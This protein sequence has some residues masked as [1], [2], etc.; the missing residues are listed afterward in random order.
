MHGNIINRKIDQDKSLAKEVICCAKKEL[1]SITELR[2]SDFDHPN[3]Q[4]GGL[5]AFRGDKS[6]ALRNMLTDP[7]FANVEI[8]DKNNDEECCYLIT[9]SRVSALLGE[10]NWDILSWTSPITATLLD[11]YA[12]QE[13]EYTGPTGITRK[14]KV[15]SFGKY[16]KVSPSLSDTTYKLEEG[17]F[18]I[19]NEQEIS[20]LGSMPTEKDE[21]ISTLPTKKPSSEEYVVDEDFGLDEIIELADCDQRQTM[22]LPFHETLIIEGPPGSGKTS[23]AIMRIP[24]LIDRQWEELGIDISKDNPFHDEKTMVILVKNNEMVHYLSN[25]T[26]SLGITS[27]RVLGIKDFLRDVCRECQVLE[28]Q[29][30]DESYELSFFKTMPNIFNLFQDSFIGYVKAYWE[31]R[32]SEIK[33]RLIGNYDDVLGQ[34]IEKISSKG[35]KGKYLSF[36][37]T[38]KEKHLDGNG[39]GLSLYLAIENWCNSLSNGNFY[40]LA[41]RMKKWQDDSD[42]YQGD[43]IKFI[44]KNKLIY[45]LDYTE[46]V[47]Q[48]KG[49]VENTVKKNNRE[50]RRRLK[51]FVA[52]FFNRH[53]IIDYVKKHP[54]ISNFE[55]EFRKAGFSEIEFNNAMDEWC[56]QIESRQWSEHDLTL[57]AYLGLKTMLL[58]D[59]NTAANKTPLLGGYKENITHMVIDEA[60]DISISHAKFFQEYIKENGTLTFCGDLHQRVHSKGFFENWKDL[61]LDDTKKIVFSKNFRQ[62]KQLGYFVKELYSILFQKYPDWSE[63]D[64]LIGPPPR[65]VPLENENEMTGKICQEIRHWMQMIPGAKIAVLWFSEYEHKEKLN[66]L[67]NEIEGSLDDLLI[68]AEVF[69]SG[70]NDNFGKG[71]VTL[72]SA[73]QIKGLEFDVVICLDLNNDLDMDFD[74]LDITIKNAIYVVLSRSQYGL[75]MIL[76]PETTIYPKLNSIVEIN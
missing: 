30:T 1:K 39:L 32:K 38:N 69:N 75:S 16:G 24:C 6:Q 68:T 76:S 40:S 53:G 57:M 15:L 35:K 43:W 65:L 5:L 13:I 63:T 27:V 62:T 66:K 20:Y 26:K 11:S 37:R 46:H 73:Q 41:P 47:K 67:A 36:M 25:L 61:G 12:N 19:K 33:K 31:Q 3:P 4:I 60:Q 28:G 64:K 45:G 54:S 55:S 34:T 58:P 59:K 50:L 29:E 49:P 71:K 7:F 74:D 9:K 51:A 22:H 70:E 72:A 52:Q 23:I 21:A 18:Y 42:R 44:E 17:E 56:V 14:M 8:D 48:E 2:L 10:G